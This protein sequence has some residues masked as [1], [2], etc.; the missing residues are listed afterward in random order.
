MEADFIHAAADAFRRCAQA[1]TTP[2]DRER[3]YALAD[4]AR[5][6]Y[7]AAYG[8]GERLA[9]VNDNGRVIGESH[10]RA[11]LTDADVDLILELRDAGLSLGQ[12]AAKFEVARSTVA[13]IC[14]GR[15]RSHTVMG[16]RLMPARDPIIWPAN[17]DEFEVCG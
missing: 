12:I 8:P 9:A 11:K 2:A 17:L 6:A 1:A 10:P 5:R 15:T 13:D 16:H 4:R 3:W 7:E 14:N